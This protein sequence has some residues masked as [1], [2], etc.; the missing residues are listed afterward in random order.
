MHPARCGFLRAA[1]CST[2]GRQ[3]GAAAPLAGLRLLDV[4]CGG[5]LL[6]ESLARMG[7]HV[8]G[9]DVNEG[10]IATAQAHAELDPALAGRLHYRTAAAEQLV[11]EGAEFDAGGW[12]GG[13][14]G[15]WGRL[16]GGRGQRAALCLVRNRP[17][18][19]CPASPAVSP[20]FA[21]ALSGAPLQACPP[22]LA[23]RPAL[24]AP[25]WWPAR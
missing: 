22:G 17:R 7:A 11:A 16:V 13:W 4:G 6:S 18:H 5:G 10:G 2:F 20:G 3:P 15:W 21:P 23:P 24:L 9:I 14:G 12:G 19:T 8:T 25:Q 1:L